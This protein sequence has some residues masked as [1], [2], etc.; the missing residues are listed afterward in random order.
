MERKRMGNTEGGTDV[1]GHNSGRGEGD[2]QTWGGGLCDDLGAP[3]RHCGALSDN[4]ISVS[5]MSAVSLLIEHTSPLK[6]A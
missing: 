4:L 3:G 2:S 5:A 6:L 1:C